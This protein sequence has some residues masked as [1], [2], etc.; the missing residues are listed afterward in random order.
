MSSTAFD[1]DTTASDIIYWATYA[2]RETASLIQKQ[3]QD[4]IQIPQI[5]RFVARY[6]LPL[7]REDLEYV[8]YYDYDF[9]WGNDGENNYMLAVMKHVS[10]YNEDTAFLAHETR[11][12]KSDVFQ[13][14]SDNDVLRLYCC[15]ARCLYFRSC[16]CNNELPLR[17]YI[18]LQPSKSHRIPFDLG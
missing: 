17:H 5:A 14:L 18:I 10:Q 16:Y 1:L 2:N 3:V 11:F 7:R 9:L 15:R 8:L 12:C 6:A 13:V 4:Y